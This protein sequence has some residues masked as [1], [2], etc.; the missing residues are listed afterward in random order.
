MTRVPKILADLSDDEESLVSFGVEFVSKLCTR[1]I[2]LGAPA[3]H[4]Y[5]MN[6]WGATTRICQNLAA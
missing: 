4:F 1:L 6:R 2:E 5:T 3:L